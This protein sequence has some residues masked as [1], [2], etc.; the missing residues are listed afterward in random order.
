VDLKPLTDHLS[1]LAR[2]RP[3]D[4]ARAQV[5]QA[6]LSKWDGVRV[7]ATKALCAWGDEASVSQAK[8]AVAQLSSKEA[9]WA[10]AGAMAEAIAPH[11]RASDAEWVAAT[12]AHVTHIENVVSLRVLTDSAV[13]AQVLPHL[14]LAVQAESNDR[15]R[16][17]LSQVLKYA[18]NR[19]AQR[20]V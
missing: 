19:H 3:N 17:A 7:A 12:L 15:R 8:N 11:L 4:E 16:K 18:Q 9:R 14:Q 1:A 5:A 20:E 10:K 6:L 2:S 13:R